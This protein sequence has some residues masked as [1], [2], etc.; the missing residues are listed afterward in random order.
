MEECT[1]SKRPARSPLTTKTDAKRH[2]ADYPTPIPGILFTQ[3]ATKVIVPSEKAQTDAPSVTI[4]IASPPDQPAKP[5]PFLRLPA[6]IRWQIYQY[7]FE[8]H[9]VEIVRRKNKTADPSKPSRYRLYHNLLKPRNPLTQSMLHYGHRSKGTALS[10]NLVFTCRA[11][12]CET[13]LL[14]YSTTQFIFNST[15]SIVLFLKTT[16]KDAQAA[17]RHVELNHIM[18]NEPRLTAFRTYK[19]RSDIAWYNACDDMAEAFSS[20]KVLHIK[21]AIYDWPIRLEVSEL[22]SIPLLLFG[23]HDGGLD[24]AEVQLQMR[25]FEDEKLKA[26]A[27]ALEQKIMEPKTFQIREDERLARKLGGPVKAKSALRLVI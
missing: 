26:V 15:N 24:Y 14:L 21:V 23:H 20:L 7:L 10:F 5:A 6:E 13:I 22:W 9:R 2:K 3:P 25:R 12:Y 1:N 4:K 11:I 19:I 18:Y 8:S 27:R 17:I 16:S